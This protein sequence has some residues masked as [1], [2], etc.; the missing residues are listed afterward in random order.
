MRVLVLSPYPERITPA[1]ERAGD[2]WHA[3][4]EQVTADDC[5]DF[6]ML[7]SFGYRYIL[8]KPILDLFDA[9]DQHSHRAFALEQRRSP[10]R[11]G[12][13]RWNAARRYN[14]RHGYRNRYGTDHSIEPS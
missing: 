3:T 5:R 12:V 4:A 7:V 6:D 1:I 13:D 2:T 10:Q 9:R 11:V 14:S 8:R